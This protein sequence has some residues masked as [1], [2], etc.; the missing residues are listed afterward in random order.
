VFVKDAKEEIVV[1]PQQALQLMASGE[2]HRHVGATGAN[3]HSS[4]SHTIFKM[5]RAS[6]ETFA[7]I[8]SKR[9]LTAGAAPTET[10]TI[11][12]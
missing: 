1:T 3:S 10:M 11:I 9:G 4:R 2:E 7:A 12:I 5:V 6:T 8:N